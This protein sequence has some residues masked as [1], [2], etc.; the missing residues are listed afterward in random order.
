[1]VAQRI[2][3]EDLAF[4]TEQLVPTVERMIELADDDDRPDPELVDMTKELL[5]KETLE[6]LQLVGFNF[7]AAVG[8]PLTEIVQRLILALVPKPGASDDVKRLQIEY[9][10]QLL[11]LAQDSDAYAR[12]QELNA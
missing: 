6:I 11:K 2:S 12:L 8:Q 5:S 4:I 7:K 10:V 3:D 1:M 9:Q